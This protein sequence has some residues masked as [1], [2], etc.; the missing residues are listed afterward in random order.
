G[1]ARTMIVVAAGLSQIGEFSFIVGQAGVSLGVLSQEQYG[2]IL[3]AA[4]LSIIIN[5]L[6]F[7]AIPGMERLLQRLP[8]FWQRMNAG[9]P[10]PEPLH[11]SLR[12]HVV[13]VGMGRVGEHISRV[14]E[15]L[16]F[17]FLVVEFDAA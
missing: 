11:E 2:L 15:R 13:I 16:H 3:A 12:D 17:P 1:A 14:L 5:P 10:T 9:G 8:G 6:M 7:R 4:V